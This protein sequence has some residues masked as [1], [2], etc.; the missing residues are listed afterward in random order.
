MGVLQNLDQNLYDI[1]VISPTNYFLFTPLLPSAAV[2][3]VEPSSLTTSIRSILD[4]IRGKSHDNVVTY[5]EASATDLQTHR[6]ENFVKVETPDGKSEFLVQYDHLVIGV[7]AISNT[8]GIPGVESYCHT[9]KNIDDAKAIKRKV[10]QNF[11]KAS[12]PGLSAAERKKLLTFVVV[13]GGP[14][15]VEFAGELL[16]FIREDLYRYFPHLVTSKEKLEEVTVAVIQSSDHIL[17]TYDEKISELAEKTF[18]KHGIKVITN[19]RVTAIRPMYLEY[20]TKKE[21]KTMEYGLCV[22]T[23]GI[24]MQGFVESVVHKMA[25]AGAQQRH[26]KALTVDDKLRVIGIDK[27]TAKGPKIFAVGD[28]CTIDTPTL[29]DKLLELFQVAD[30][31]QNG[32]LSLEEFLSLSEYLSK[33]YPQVEVYLKLVGKKAK[34]LF[35]SVDKAGKGYLNFVEFESLLRDIDRMVRP[36]PATAQVAQQQGKYVGGYLNFLGKETRS[37]DVDIAKW[38]DTVPDGKSETGKGVDS[39]LNIEL[40]EA[41]LEPD[42]KD[43]EF[44]PFRYSHFGSLAYIGG[45]VAAIDF[46]K[47]FSMGGSIL[48]LWLWKSVYLSKQV[49]L[50]QRID[51]GFDW[52]RTKIW[53]RDVGNT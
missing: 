36:L 1:T 29:V 25:R 47:G 48:T 21:S 2:G 37:S 40:L 35:D 38:L 30:V 53:G 17:N 45:D 9:L 27:I 23:T 20:S 3:T 34:K 44:K 50:K 4:K 12:V 16:D 28:C 51:L 49:T 14:T 32:T 52:I 13:G 43:D 31:D 15:G 39:G 33:K 10:K 22:W 18:L 19:A 6:G 41:I 42:Q 8:F 24:G 26:Y 7:G 46:G 11:E 5:I